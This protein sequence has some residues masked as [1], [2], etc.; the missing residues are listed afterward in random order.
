[1]EEDARLKME[2]AKVLEQRKLNRDD[3][4]QSAIAYRLETSFLKKINRTRNQ[5]ERQEATEVARKSRRV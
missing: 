2:E 4:K 1:M 3:E 5:M